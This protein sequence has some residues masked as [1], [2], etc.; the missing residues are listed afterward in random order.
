MALNLLPFR[1]YDENDV[2]NLFAFSPAVALADTTTDGQ[3]SQGSIVKV[4][5]GNF[6]QDLI[7]Y[8][9]DSYLGKTDYPFVAGDMYPTNSLL[10]TGCAA[11]ETK[12]AVLGVTLN[13]TA[14]NDE[15]GEKLLYNATKKEELQAV[16]PGQS[17]PVATKGIFTFGAN[18][19][20]A[21]T[22]F[23]V[24]AGVAT[25]AGGKITGV[26]LGTTG[27]DGVDQVIGTV[28]GTGERVSQNSSLTDQFAG[29]FVIVKL[30]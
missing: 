24:G 25:A 11:N 16:L 15:N 4:A 3:A 14:K 27:Q 12:G 23:T 9:S 19:F 13:Q 2:V 17:V 7:S 18:A 10:I 5:N 8:G 29:K 30:G 28:L 22:T 26:A 1:Q 21:N 20:D 6:N